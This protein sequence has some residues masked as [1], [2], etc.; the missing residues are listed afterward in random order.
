VGHAEAVVD[1]VLEPTQERFEIVYDEAQRLTRLVQDLRTLTLSDAGEL[2]LFL[3]VVPPAALLEAA[4]NAQ[5]PLAEARGIA[6]DVEVA[7]DLDDIF[8]DGDRVL[9]VLHN[10][11][12]NALRYTPDGGRISLAAQPHQDGVEFRVCDSGPG[13]AAE[14][15]DRVFHRFYKGDRSRQREVLSASADPRQGESGSGLGLAIARSIIEAHGGRIWAES[16]EGEGAV[17]AFVLMREP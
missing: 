2:S 7:D 12:S 4:A 6:L 1:G 10:L 13:I 11:L 8:A 5:R 15:V 3:D 14:D 17:F 9:Q 16:H